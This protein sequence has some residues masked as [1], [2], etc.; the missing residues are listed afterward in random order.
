MTNATA[1][2]NANANDHANYYDDDG[3]SGYLGILFIHLL[4]LLGLDN[5][6]KEG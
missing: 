5:E 2:A 4:C 1:N 6:E 3:F